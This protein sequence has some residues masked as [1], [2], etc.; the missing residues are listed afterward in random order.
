MSA[1]AEGP[2]RLAKLQA[3][4][5][6]ILTL[7]ILSDREE[8]EV[9]ARL[10]PAVTGAAEGLARL[11]GHLDAVCFREVWRAVAVALNRTLY[12]DVATEAGFSPQVGTLV[13]LLVEP[14]VSFAM[15]SFVT[16]Q[17]ELRRFTSHPLS[18]PVGSCPGIPAQSERQLEAW[19]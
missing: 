4:P 10:M 18:L 11:A 12:N 5:A 7:L 13:A 17:D 15:W 8:G 14:C 1:A 6:L 19:P 3:D 9:S 16:G 2:T